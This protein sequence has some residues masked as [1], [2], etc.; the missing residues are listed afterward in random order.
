MGTLRYVQ[1]QFPTLYPG[2]AIDSF[3]LIAPGAPSVP[4]PDGVDLAP[5]PRDPAQMGNDS[6]PSM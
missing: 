6:R 5:A 3:P 2:G 4:L 1:Q